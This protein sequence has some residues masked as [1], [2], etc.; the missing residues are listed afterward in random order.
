MS[1]WLEHHTFINMSIYLA[2]RQRLFSAAIYRNIQTALRKCESDQILKLG[3]LALRSTQFMPIAR[4]LQYQ[5]LKELRLE[6][7]V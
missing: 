6:G 5:I 2:I 3:H 7:N 4:A 1:N